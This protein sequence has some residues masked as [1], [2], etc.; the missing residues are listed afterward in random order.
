MNI[1]KWSQDGQAWE[2]AVD[3]ANIDGG[4]VYVD[5]ENTATDVKIGCNYT[6]GAEASFFPGE[7]MMSFMTRRELSAA[8]AEKVALQMVRLMEL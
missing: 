5:M 7:I 2:G 6:G 4:G 3:D 1:Y 8:T